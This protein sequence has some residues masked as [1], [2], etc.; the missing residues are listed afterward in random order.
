MVVNAQCSSLEECTR[1]YKSLDVQNNQLIGD[2]TEVDET[3]D[4]LEHEIERSKRQKRSSE[5]YENRQLSEMIN[6]TKNSRSHKA[7]IKDCD[8]SNPQHLQNITM[9]IC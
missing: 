8:P 2:I 7:A 1:L 4:H 5:V 9:K 6:M 3:I